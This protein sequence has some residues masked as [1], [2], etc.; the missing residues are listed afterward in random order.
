MSEVD[1]GASSAHLMPGVLSE[2]SR[3]VRRR[4]VRLRSSLPSAGGGPAEVDSHRWFAVL[5]DNLGTFFTQ[6][7]VE[8]RS[9]RDVG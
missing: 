2:D 9:I 1:V 4:A 3:V 7:L 8:E 6:D 5:A